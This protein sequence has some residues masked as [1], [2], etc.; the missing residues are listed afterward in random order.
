MEVD[1]LSRKWKGKGKS[2][3][4]KKGSKKGKESRSVKVYGESK[5]EHTR[6]DGECRNCG[7]YGHKAA[8]LLVQ[9]TT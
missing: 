6:F 8:D 7:K 1:D 4:G 3:K 9:T 5:V 2:G